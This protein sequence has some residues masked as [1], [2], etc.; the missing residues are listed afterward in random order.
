MKYMCSNQITYFFPILSSIIYSL[1]SHKLTQIVNKALNDDI[2][3][4]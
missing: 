1:L 2:F 3:P 4:A